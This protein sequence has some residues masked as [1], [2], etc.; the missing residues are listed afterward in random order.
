MKKKKI[1]VYRRRKRRAGLLATAEGTRQEESERERELA[2]KTAALKLRATAEEIKK[3]LETGMIDKTTK[4][5]NIFPPP[6][7][8]TEYYPFHEDKVEKNL[9]IS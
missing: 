9:L 6:P 7:K 3:Y 5:A 1:S 2:G 4:S 8:V